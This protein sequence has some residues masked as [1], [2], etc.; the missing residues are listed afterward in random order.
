MFLF[1]ELELR[2][3]CLRVDVIVIVVKSVLEVVEEWEVYISY[4][5]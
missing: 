4:P 3:L 5:P 1:T 2:M